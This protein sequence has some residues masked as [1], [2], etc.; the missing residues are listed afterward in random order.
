MSIENNTSI[1]EEL[2]RLKTAKED[3]R[4][5]INDKGGSVS[6][7]QTF[8][9]FAAAIR[10]I[11]TSG[12]GS[13]NAD[14]CVVTKYTAPQEAYTRIDSVV[15]SGLTDMT[16]WD[17]YEFELSAWNGTYHLHASTITETDPDK[18]TF[19]L[20]DEDKY[21]V[22]GEGNSEDGGDV[23]AFTT[24]PD[25]G[26]VSYYGSLLFSNELS[27][28]SWENGEYGFN[29]D[30]VIELNTTDVPAVEE[31]ISAETINYAGGEFSYVDTPV[32]I[33]EV[34]ESPTQ[35]GIYLRHNDKLIGSHIKMLSL[36]D[37]PVLKG[38]FDGIFDN[39]FFG[40]DPGIFD[41]PDYDWVFDNVNLYYPF[42]EE[43]LNSR[44]YNDLISGNKLTATGA[45]VR[46]T[47]NGEL[48]RCLINDYD[49]HNYLS[50]KLL[51]Y[52]TDLPQEFT[53]SALVRPMMGVEG[54]VGES[55]NDD[56][57][58]EI[59][60]GSDN[61]GFGLYY[62]I[63]ASYDKFSMRVG[64]MYG[65]A[66]I[67]ADKESVSSWTLITARC[68]RNENTGRLVLQMFANGV[69]GNEHELPVDYKIKFSSNIGLLSRQATN[70]WER[71][72]HSAPV[73]LD[74][75]YLYKGAASDRL[76][77]G[78]AERMQEL[79]F[80]QIPQ[81]EAI[82]RYS[83][84]W[85]ECTFDTNSPQHP[86]KVSEIFHIGVGWPMT[87]NIW[88]TDGGV[89]VQINYP[90]M[91]KPT[92]ISIMNTAGSRDIWNFKDAVFQALDEP[93]GEWV[94]LLQFQGSNPDWGTTEKFE[95]DSPRQYR[96]FRVRFLSSWR[97]GEKDGV[98]DVVL[99]GGGINIHRIII[100][101]GTDTSQEE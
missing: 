82:D 1:R 88:K 63:G 74:E 11:P 5:A 57:L 58:I 66:T 80:I 55:Y 37:S 19:Q 13:G 15:V 98:Y 40:W 25:K 18:M 9:D 8:S 89:F 86:D 44:T 24:S 59:G 3:I 53:I 52:L 84:T 83:D 96:S 10:K 97:D 85:D 87:D 72:D 65:L 62:N 60:S 92:A 35:Y 93:T 21:I 81:Q 33:S 23:W 41:W 71:D 61:T 4:S 39:I 78:M 29:A 31:E 48:G 54:G 68:R 32:A 76:I 17:E 94:T 101:R 28:G 38:L 45:C 43:D 34:E 22:H 12:G 47:P 70:P 50:G 16:I 90:Y 67:Y 73:C 99:N 91:F 7:S 2:N 100:Y 51:N 77:L 26:S 42:D 27:S 46:T 6:T 30:V 79:G 64:D 75:V 36:N 20:G 14:F 56:P 69:S 95:V 49:R